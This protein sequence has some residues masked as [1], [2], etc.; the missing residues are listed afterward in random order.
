MGNNRFKLFI[1]NFLVYGLGGVISKIVPMIM[2]PL[3]VRLY[4]N[5]TYIGYNDLFTTVTSLAVS[6]AMFGM[7]DAMFRFFFEKEEMEYKKSICSTSFFFVF[8]MAVLMAGI[9]CLFSGQI[10][11]FIWGDAQYYRLVYIMAIY[12][13]MSATNSII[14]APTRIQNKRKVFLVTNSLSSLLSY[15]LAIPM[16]LRGSYLYAMPLAMVFSV[17]ILEIIFL[18]MNKSWFELKYFK[19][20]RLKELLIVGLPLVPNTLVYWV[21]NSCDRLMIKQILGAGANGIYSVASKFGHISNLIYTAFSGGWLYFSYSTMKDED[22]VEMKSRI[23]EYLGIISFFSTVALMAIA[24]PAYKIL[25]TTEYMSGY[26]ITP[27]LFITPLLLMLYQTIANQFTIIKKTYINTISLS[28]GA[29]VN[30]VLNLIL[31]KS[32][33]I[34]GAALA[35]L[36]GYIVTLIMTYIMLRRKKLVKIRSKFFVSTVAFCIYFVVWRVWWNANLF[37]NIIGVVVFAV[38]YICLYKEDLEKLIQNK[39]KEA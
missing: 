25:F 39:R 4:P 31:I 9:C 6:V 20:S 29:I 8:G 34:E 10:A 37:M 15:G 5:S 28:I 26:L 17:V 36:I 24:K 27:Y 30:V 16:I 38:L 32:I 2:V 11:A 23:F 19:A 18:C 21:Y 33:G 12:I 35:T 13:L 14:A 3:L 1:E 22:Q 7:Y